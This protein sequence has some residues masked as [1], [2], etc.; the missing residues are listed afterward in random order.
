MPEPLIECPSCGQEVPEG[1]F[2]KLCGGLLPTVDNANPP[3]EIEVQTEDLSDSNMTIEEDVTSSLP[4]FEIVIDDMDYESSVILLSRAELEVIDDELDR[5][6]EKTRATRQA[7]Q[8]QQ[9]DKAVLTLRAET[10][11]A[12][13]E[14]LKQRKGEL[15]AVKQKLILQTILEGL[16]KHEE[17][18]TKLKAIEGALDK[19]VYNEQHEEIVRIIKELRSNLKDSIK[20]GKKWMK[21]IKKTIKALQKEISRLD[22][23]YKIGDL[24]RSSYEDSTSKIE[25]AMLI[26]EGGQKR[27]DE[28]LT[29]AMKR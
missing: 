26:L 27:L 25:R 15:I 5:I 9:A 3:L 7:L 6:V 22:A 28:L 20:L 24:S 23:K 17:R 11:R 10:L 12:E 21:G 1:R 2:C 29:I 19:D 4:H 13:F 8:L 16:N 18:L 14:R